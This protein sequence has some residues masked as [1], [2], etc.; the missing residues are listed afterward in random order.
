MQNRI[1][2]LGAHPD[3]IEFAMGATLAKLAR[4]PRNYIFAAVFS[5]ALQLPENKNILNEL[6]NS[7]K[8]YGIDYYI[9]DFRTR[10]F[11]I[12]SPEIQDRI[13]KLK[14]EFHPNIVYSPS[15]NA[16][17]PDHAVIG[18]AVSSVFQETSILVYEDIR[19]NHHQLINYW[20]EVTKADAEKK[21]KALKCYQSQFKRKYFNFDQIYHLIS[22]RGLQIGKKYAEGFE[23]LRVIDAA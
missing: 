17:H 22:A 10:F 9:F 12:D 4:D 2:I 3:D 14:Q 21:I 19:G 13:F 20:H 16:L 15:P 6:R 23:N 7:M 5:P 11:V 8:I 18:K 1:L